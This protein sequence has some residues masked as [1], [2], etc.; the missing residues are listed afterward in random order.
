MEAFE[1][2]PGRIR[3]I[4]GGWSEQNMMMSSAAREIL[5]K[6][7]AQAVPT[8]SRSCFKLVSNTCKTITS[9]TS[10]YTSKYRW[11]GSVNNRKIH[12]VRW[13]K[14]TYPILRYMEVWGL[15]MCTFYQER[16]RKYKV[17]YAQTSR[18]EQ[19]YAL[20]FNLALLGKQSW[21]LLEKPESLCPS[22]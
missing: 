5:I 15:V 16:G 21:R 22:P 9:C 1:H 2:I 7:V 3:N 8:Y 13:P 17:T 18:N 12:W 14:L 19:I 10:K 20:I 11:G 4:A 6:F